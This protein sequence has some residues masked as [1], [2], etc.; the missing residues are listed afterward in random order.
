MASSLTITYVPA[1]TDEVDVDAL[2]LNLEQDTPSSYEQSA[3][4]NDL[5]QMLAYARSGQSARGYSKSGC[6]AV[7]SES[8]VKFTLLAYVWPSDLS[9]AY[10]LSC[11]QGEVDEGVRYDRETEGNVLFDLADEY[12]LPY[13]MEAVSA[14]WETP[15]YNEYSEQ[16]SSPAIEHDGAYLLLADSCFGIA[17]VQGTAV[18]YMH[19]I[20]IEIEKSTLADDAESIT[21]FSA[22]LTASY[23]DEDGEAQSEELELTIPQCVIDYLE[24]CPDDATWVTEGSAGPVDPEEYP[25]AVIYYSTCTGTVKAIRYE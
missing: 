3:N 12:T 23:T 11:D 15:C 2:W 8:G 22:T 7:L 20:T 21:N 19:E 14:S 5:A 6:T 10:S 13:C 24:L 17:R 9:L 1:E 16:V 4:L 25:A 18:G